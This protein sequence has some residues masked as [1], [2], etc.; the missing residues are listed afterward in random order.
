[1]CKIAF[2]VLGY[3]R[4]E[5]NVSL[6]IEEAESVTE[7][8]SPFEEKFGVILDTWVFTLDKNGKPVKVRK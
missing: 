5:Q 2:H 3:F 6:E 8:P 7:L 4:Y 1:L